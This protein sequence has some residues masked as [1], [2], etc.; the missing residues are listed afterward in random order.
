MKKIKNTGYKLTISLNS[1][2]SI[3]GN[4][5]TSTAQFI[6]DKLLKKYPLFNTSIKEM[7]GVISGNTHCNTH[8]STLLQADFHS[9]DNLIPQS[10]IEEIKENISPEIHLHRYRIA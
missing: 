2:E 10:I 7:P 8:I 5:A 6:L 4:I 9:P 1:A 3:S